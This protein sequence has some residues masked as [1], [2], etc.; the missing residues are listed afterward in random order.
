MITISN[1][2]LRLLSLQP[3]TGTANLISEPDSDLQGEGERVDSTHTFETKTAIT[4]LRVH[5][6]IIAPG[7][8]NNE[9]GL[10]SSA[11]MPT[12]AF[13]EGCQRLIR[14][15]ASVFFA[16]TQYSIMPPAEA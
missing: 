7:S 1:L 16:D 4:I 12:A 8:T 6:I 13:Q 15:S 10:R 9:S 3:S 5:I 11:C 2:Q 14:K